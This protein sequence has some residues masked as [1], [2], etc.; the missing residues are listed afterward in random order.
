[1]SETKKCAHPACNCQARENDDYCSTY[2][3]GEA[4]IADIICGCGHPSCA[5]QGEAVTR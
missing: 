2:C 3:E 4:E 1:M 5:A